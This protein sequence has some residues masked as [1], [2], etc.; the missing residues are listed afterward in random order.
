MSAAAQPI[1]DA[2]GI[3]AYLGILDNLKTQYANLD[4]EVKKLGKPASET[5]ERVD[6]L[7]GAVI[8][9]Q[10]K[11]QT[12]ATKKLEGLESQI[13]EVSKRQEIT[14]PQKSVGLQF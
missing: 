5:L 10:N 2:E 13:K 9:L 6:K 3:K 14:Q 1:L 8:D 7:N 12:E 4:A 11:Y